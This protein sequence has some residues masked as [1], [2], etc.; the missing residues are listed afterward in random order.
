MACTR[1]HSGPHAIHSLLHWPQTVTA[2]VAAAS[3]ST[4]RTPSLF[5]WPLAEFSQLDPPLSSSLSARHARPLL[6]PFPSPR[7]KCRWALPPLAASLR[8][9][10]PVR[11]GCVA[12]SP[13]SPRHR[14]AGPEH[15]RSSSTAGFV[16]M[17]HLH[18]T[19]CHAAARYAALPPPLARPLSH[20][21]TLRHHA[22]RER[23]DPARGARVP[24]R[25]AW[26]SWAVLSL[27]QVVPTRPWA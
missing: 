19:S 6:P 5:L 14:F 16:L 11:S 13:S 21:P 8:R 2:P 1:G 18:P 24:H 3:L 22:A 9:T 26:A 7:F 4:A 10:L 15:G 12:A 20:R 17:S 27:S 25:P 23:G